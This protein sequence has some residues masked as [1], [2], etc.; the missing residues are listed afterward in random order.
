[1]G[2]MDSATYL[3]ECLQKRIL[4]FIQKYHHIGDILFWPDLMSSHMQAQCKPGLSLKTSIM[5]VKRNDNGPNK[6]G[7]LKDIELCLS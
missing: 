6:S 3:D 2:T 5:C 4:L 1:M 7:Q